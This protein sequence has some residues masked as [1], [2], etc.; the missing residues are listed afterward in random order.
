M[1]PSL[2][3]LSLSVPF[4]ASLEKWEDRL[5]PFTSSDVAATLAQRSVRRPSPPPL[6][7]PLSLAASLS[8]S[9]RV[10]RDSRMQLGYTRSLA[11][12]ASQSPASTAVACML[13]GTRLEG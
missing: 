12:P 2:D 13:L 9:N 1:I 6:E 8:V 7:L 5:T 11:V 4:T 10:D 3:S